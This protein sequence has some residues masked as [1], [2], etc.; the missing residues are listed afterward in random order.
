MGLQE[1]R[2]LCV[3]LPS[4]HNGVL[5]GSTL[6]FSTVHPGIRQAKQRTRLHGYQTSNPQVQPTPK[7]SFQSS[8]VSADRHVKIS[9]YCTADVAKVV[10]P[11]GCYCLSSRSEWVVKE[12]RG[13]E[14]E[15]VSHDFFTWITVFVMCFFFWVTIHMYKFDNWNCNW[16]TILHGSNS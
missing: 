4:W 15:L 5:G 16:V 14:H 12:L 8:R 2:N 13:K 10:I 7:Y 11:W 1:R 3:L 6:N 9:A